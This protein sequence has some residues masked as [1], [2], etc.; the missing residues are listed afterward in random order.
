MFLRSS[1]SILSENSL[2]LWERARVR[3]LIFSVSV[4]TPIRTALTERPERERKLP[5]RQDKD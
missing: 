5:P 3:G 1:R 2:A 4:S